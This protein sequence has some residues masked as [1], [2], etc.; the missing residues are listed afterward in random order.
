MN[1]VRNSQQAV[2]PVPQNGLSDNATS[3][4]LA[5]TLPRVSRAG[6]RVR[7]N[8]TGILSALPN[9]HSFSYW[10]APIF[11]PAS[12]SSR[13]RDSDPNDSPYACTRGA[14]SGNRS[15]ISLIEGAADSAPSTLSTPKS[16]LRLLRSAVNLSL[17]RWLTSR[18]TLTSFAP[19]ADSTTCCPLRG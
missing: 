10:K 15:A 2:L 16:G 7:R 9:D 17:S 13:S 6:T 3:V 12:T 1:P 5:S 14:I 4:S 8:A 18:L 11:F 19:E